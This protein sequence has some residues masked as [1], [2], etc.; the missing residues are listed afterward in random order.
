[1]ITSAAHNLRFVE[2][3]INEKCLIIYFELTSVA[4]LDTCFLSISIVNFTNDTL[5]S[6]HLFIH[7]LPKAKETAIKT[8]LK[9]AKQAPCKRSR[10]D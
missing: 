4:Y 7:H 5:Y 10:N 1:M 3:N 8:I 6:F 9:M 2:E